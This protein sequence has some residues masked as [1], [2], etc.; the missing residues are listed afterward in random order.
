M[1]QLVGL[2]CLNSL[3]PIA[4]H[5][6]FLLTEKSKHDDHRVPLRAMLTKRR[7]APAGNSFV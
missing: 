4:E 7:A 6:A 2:R 5:V 3:I 1:A